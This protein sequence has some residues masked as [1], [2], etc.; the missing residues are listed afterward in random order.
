MSI[1]LCFVSRSQTRYPMHCRPVNLPLQS[2]HVLHIIPIEALLRQYYPPYSVPYVPHHYPPN[3]PPII[4][5]IIMLILVIEQG[6]EHEGGVRFHAISL[7][8]LFSRYSCRF[9]FCLRQ[10]NLGILDIQGYGKSSTYTGYTGR[11]REKHFCIYSPVVFHR[12]FQSSFSS[13][14]GLRR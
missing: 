14:S 8:L 13:Y 5:T 7:I 2:R 3:F 12:I 9:Y 1:V 11:K 4:P 10:W 6:T